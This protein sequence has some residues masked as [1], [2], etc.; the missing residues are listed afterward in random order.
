M[1]L[2]RMIGAAPDLVYIGG[3]FACERAAWVKG[4]CMCMCM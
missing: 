3:D 4:L 1:V 2:D